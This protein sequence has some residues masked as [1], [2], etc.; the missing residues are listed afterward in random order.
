MLD[1]FLGSSIGQRIGNILIAFLII[2]LGWSPT[3]N[4]DKCATMKLELKG[5]ITGVTGRSGYMYVTINNVVKPVSMTVDNEI[6]RKGFEE[7]HFYEVG[8]SI[9]KVANSKEVTVKNK[10][11]VVV[12]TMSCY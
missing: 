11:S 3:Y 1:R 8:D 4:A 9:I 6:F 5:V 12:F 2:R 10:D 7:G